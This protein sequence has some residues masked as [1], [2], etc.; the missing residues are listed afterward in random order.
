[1]KVQLFRI[2]FQYFDKW[3]QPCQVT[4]HGKS[5]EEAKEN[6]YAWSLKN[7]DGDFSIVN[8]QRVL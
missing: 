7:G 3:D 1:M 2:I 4:L 8:L 6:A 5:M